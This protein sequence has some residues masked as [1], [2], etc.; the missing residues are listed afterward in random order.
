M[1]AP[2]LLLSLAFFA[3]VAVATGFASSS[4][5]VG[6]LFVLTSATTAAALAS[7]RRAHLLLATLAALLFALGLMRAAD[8]P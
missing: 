7:G 4:V 1:T 6:A 2:L 8:A 3:G 5:E